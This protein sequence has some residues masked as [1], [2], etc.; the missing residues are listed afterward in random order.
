MLQ[1]AEAHVLV[2]R[3]TARAITVAATATAAAVTGLRGQAHV[4]VGRTTAGASFTS[5]DPV[6]Q[7]VMWTS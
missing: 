6:G 3:P 2:E 5:V 7:Y 1:T 4:V